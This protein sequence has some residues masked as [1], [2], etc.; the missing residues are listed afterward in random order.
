MFYENKKAVIPP[1]YYG[2]FFFKIN[3]AAVLTA[4]CNVNNRRLKL[5]LRYGFLAFQTAV[6]INSLNA[7]MPNEPCLRAT[8]SPFGL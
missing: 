4:D 6:F 1:Q 5:S 7:S 8:S 2:F 3:V